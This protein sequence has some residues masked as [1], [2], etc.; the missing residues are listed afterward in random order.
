MKKPI[1]FDNFKRGDKIIC[2]CPK[3]KEE[4]YRGVIARVALSKDKIYIFRE[5]R[6]RTWGAPIIKGQRTWRALM[7]E[8]GTWNGAPDSYENQS[9]NLYLDRVDDWRSVMTN[10]LA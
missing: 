10:E 6:H 7:R 1:K 8:D 9:Y 2:Y 3:T 5:D 4:L